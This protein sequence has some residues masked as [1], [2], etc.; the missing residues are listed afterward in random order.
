MKRITIYLKWVEKNGGK[1]INTISR[2]CTS[3]KEA[4]DFMK[5]HENNTKKTQ[6][7]FLTI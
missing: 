6:E 3:E 5:M 2:V 1:I 7:S 4:I